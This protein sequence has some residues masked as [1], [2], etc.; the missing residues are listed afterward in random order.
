MKSN[1]LEFK[2]ELNDGF[3]QDAIAFLN[4]RDGGVME[5]LALEQKM[6]VETQDKTLVEMQGKTPDKILQVLKANPQITLA[7]VAEAIAKSLSAVERAS[8]KLVKA[9]KLKRVGS[10]KGGHWQ[11]L[12]DG[13]E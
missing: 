5:A 11:V 4:Y 3:K 10:P 12:E 7:G 1:H 2:R 9:G 6:T 13:N 8:S